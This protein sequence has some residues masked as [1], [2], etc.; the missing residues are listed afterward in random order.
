MTGTVSTEGY[1]NLVQV[2]YCV[3]SPEGWSNCFYLCFI[4]R[5]E[6]RKQN[7]RW[8][9]CFYLCLITRSLRQRRDK[10]AQGVYR[11]CSPFCHDCGDQ[12]ACGNHWAPLQI[13][14]LD[15]SPPNC[16][17][18]PKSLPKPGSGQRL[19]GMKANSSAP[20]SP[21]EG[22][23]IQITTQQRKVHTTQLA[24]FCLI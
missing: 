24:Y 2:F 21:G 8:S 12:S 3:L 16:N 14:R 9:N 23:R 20:Y 13:P 19:E 7:R 5:W 1:K 15:V 22:V 17:G 10:I 6:L 11:N 18:H 4:P